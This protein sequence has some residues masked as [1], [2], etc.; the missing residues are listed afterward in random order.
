MHVK[1]TRDVESEV[2]ETDQGVSIQMLIGPD[3]GPNF[4]E[5]YRRVDN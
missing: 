5:L 3:E 2:L 1:K 4:R